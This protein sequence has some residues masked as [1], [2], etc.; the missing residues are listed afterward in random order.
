MEGLIRSRV[1]RTSAVATLLLL[2]VW[3][4][5]PYVLSDVGTSAFVNAEVTRVSSPIAGVVT[6]ALPREG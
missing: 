2:G 4:L 1:A 3:G 6:P 5:A